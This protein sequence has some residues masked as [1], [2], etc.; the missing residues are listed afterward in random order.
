V[1]VE[2][3]DSLAESLLLSE[4]LLGILQVSAHTEAVANAAEEVNLPRLGSLDKN[5]LGLV[6]ELGGEDLVDLC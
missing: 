1:L 3:G 4:L 2:P 5:I 6:T